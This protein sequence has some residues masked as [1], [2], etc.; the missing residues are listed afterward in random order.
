MSETADLDTFT[1]Q[2]RDWLDANAN[3]KP[4]D[5]GHG[6]IEWGKGEFSV[7]VFHNLEMDEERS[8]LA[9]IS[10]WTQKKAEV[11]YHR[12]EW[13]TELGGLGLTT[14]HK[15][16][17][18]RIEA[19][20]E[21]PTSHELH[22]VTTELIAPTIKLLGTDWQKD[23]WLEKWTTARELCC[24]LFSEPAAGSDLANVAMKADKDGDEW[25]LN[26]QKVWSSGAQFAEWGMAVCRTNVDAPKHKG[27]TVFA[28]PLQ[29][30]EGVEVRQI[31]QMSGGTSF[32]EIF[33]TDARIPDAYRVGEVG[34]GWKVALT[35]LGFERTSS[36][37]G[38][39]KHGGNWREFKALCDHFEAGKDPI[40][41]DEMAKIYIRY[42]VMSINAERVYSQV[43]AG[44]AP[45]AEGS[46]GKIFWT[47]SM[48]M[49]SDA[50]SKVLGARLVADTG[51][52]GTYEWGEHVL[53]A[54]GY[55]IAGGSD[56][57]QRNIIGERVLGLPGEPRVDKGIP[58]KDVPK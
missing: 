42:R 26:G 56:E 55:R 40:L 7:A 19:E 11:G 21:I 50:V 15:Q 10:A 35:I 17:F 12:V 25:V 28:V 45:G 24:Q 6:T 23:Q 37:A 27:I 48:R 9:K 47:D 44:Q 18:A 38:H 1:A 14:D 20:Y 5:T 33:V 29:N 3:Q 58:Y 22:S 57:I 46:I 30:H 52:W 54:P 32:N 41:R 34:E 39:E 4:A 16:A 49:M 8:M 2:A 36:G 31:K 43:K 53:G 13:E 51:E